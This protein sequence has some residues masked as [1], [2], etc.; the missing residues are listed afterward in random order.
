MVKRTRVCRNCKRFTEEKVCPNCKSADLSSSWKG[1][2][3]VL[4]AENS[5]VAKLMNIGENG[6]Y[7]VYVG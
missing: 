6:K 1:L 5:E 4:N 3:I 7:A 2:V